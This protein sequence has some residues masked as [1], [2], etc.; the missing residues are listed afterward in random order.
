VEE[1]RL[2][3]KKFREKAEMLEKPFDNLPNVEYLLILGASIIVALAADLLAAF[4]RRVLH[5][6]RRSGRMKHH[7]P[8]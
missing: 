3:R 7:R 2:N 6:R 8:A 5:D 4:V 1:P